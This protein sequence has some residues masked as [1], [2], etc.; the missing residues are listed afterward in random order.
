MVL[1]ALSWTQ[2]LSFCLDCGNLDS[3]HGPCETS[4]VI[5]GYFGNLSE[6]QGFFCIIGVCYRLSWRLHGVTDTRV[7]L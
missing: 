1:V 4:S 7:Y 6:P 3:E 5:L 2:I